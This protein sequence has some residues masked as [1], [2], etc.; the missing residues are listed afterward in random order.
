M[1]ILDLTNYPKN[2]GKSYLGANGSKKC[3]KINGHDYM[4]KFPSP[5][6]QKTELSYANG[7][8]T[9][10]IG[11]HIFELTQVPVQ[12][13][14]LAKYNVNGKEKIVVACKDMRNKGDELIPFTGLKNQCFDS[15][16]NGAGTELSEII[17]TLNT[18]SLFDNHLLTQHFWNIFVVDA[19][20]ANFDRHNGNWGYIYNDIRNTVRIAPVYDCGSCLFAQADE[21][22]MKEVLTN[23][24][25]LNY[26]IF[27]KPESAIKINNK[28]INYYDFISSLQNSD[29][30][31]ALKRIYSQLSINKINDV[32]LNTPFINDLQKKFYITILDNRFKY[33]IEKPYEKLLK[34]EQEQNY[35]T[36]LEKDNND[37]GFEF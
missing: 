32:I 36:S 27:K 30:N 33:I 18:Q 14:L 9:E 6:T 7:C 13:T 17:E 16:Y 35:D 10:Y 2:N 23:T 12:E 31:E 34:L 24:D 28:K 11:C 29:C 22:I 8:I 20:I 1:K 15:P 21:N 26:R 4:V 37:I 5:A 19:L 3:I 25:E